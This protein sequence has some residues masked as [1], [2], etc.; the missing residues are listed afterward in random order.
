MA[1]NLNP[2]FHED[3]LDSNFNFFCT[4]VRYDESRKS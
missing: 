3:R 2:N 4:L 1:A